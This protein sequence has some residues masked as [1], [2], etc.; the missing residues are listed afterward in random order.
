MALNPKKFADYGFD[1]EEEMAERI[2]LC[3]EEPEAF[4]K[5]P[6]HQKVILI[7]APP[8]IGKDGKERKPVEQ[9]VLFLRP[10]V[11]SRVT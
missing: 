1:S 6:L 10:L 9:D 7:P 11:C 5:L 4:A 2:R 3:R 8:L